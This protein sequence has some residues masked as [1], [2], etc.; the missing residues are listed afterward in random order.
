MAATGGRARGLSLEAT[1]RAG[2]QL[3]RQAAQRAALSKYF[4][5]ITMTSANPTDMQWHELSQAEGT[6]CTAMSAAS[7]FSSPRAQRCRDCVGPFVL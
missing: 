3:N 4:V 2:V 5:V 1:E 7:S 6:T